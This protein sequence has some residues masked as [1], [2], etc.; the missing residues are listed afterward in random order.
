MSRYG[1]QEETKGTQVVF[2]DSIDFLTGFESHIHALRAIRA[3]AEKH[4]VAV[5]IT[6]EIFKRASQSRADKHPRYTDLYP[7]L[8]DYC[9]KVLLL[10]RD[11]YYNLNTNKKGVLEIGCAT[12]NTS[13]ATWVDVPCNF[14]KGSIMP[15]R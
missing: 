5:V 13:Q 3:F 15:M 6:V 2:L 4:Y 11:E 14:S 10:Y 12:K 8:I 9:A 1:L 7:E